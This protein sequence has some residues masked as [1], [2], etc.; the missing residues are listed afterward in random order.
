MRATRPRAR[1]V[2][3]ACSGLLLAVAVAASACGGD[4]DDGPRSVDIA[5]TEEGKASVLA[6]PNDV[7]AGEVEIAYTNNGR[8]GHDLQL[9]RV[10]DQRS[11][12]TVI[13]TFGRV[14]EGQ[15][16]P[17]WLLAAGGVGV[18]APGKTQT[19]TQVLEPGMYYAF[20]I[21]GT[22]GAPEPSDVPI[23]EVKG[24]ASGEELEAEGGTV[25][26]IDYGFKAQGLEAGANEI[27]FENTGGQPHHL[28]ASH[29]KGKA[30][31]ED[32]E[33]A[34]KSNRRPPPL[35]EEGTQSTAVLDGG[36][37]QIVTINL[38]P[39]RYAFYCFISDR[40]GGPPHVVKGMVDEVEVE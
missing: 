24:E 23:I 35:V 9:I 14:L 4:D 26:A 11:T 12:E 3:L 19:V 10:E 2:A 33:K 39:G 36:G 16:L 1:S 18:T 17:D 7:Q 21:E 22:Q 30:T 34:F 8:K 31:I 15:P 40:Q 25:E 28:L 5:V 32:V 29:I 13:R 20:D 6:A 27:L 38:K 37:S